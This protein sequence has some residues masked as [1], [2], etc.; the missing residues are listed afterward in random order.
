MKPLSG[1]V[2]WSGMVVIGILAVP[3]AVLLGMI[4]AVWKGSGFLLR[5]FD[6]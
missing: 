3:T 4:S 2:F 6:G 1:I 5:R